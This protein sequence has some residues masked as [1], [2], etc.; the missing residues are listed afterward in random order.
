[1]CQKT[2]ACNHLGEFHA[3]RPHPRTRAST[4]Q[5]SSPAIA[6][7]ARARQRAPPAQP[8]SCVTQIV[9]R[10]M[11][12]DRFQNALPPI[13]SNGGGA[14][15]VERGEAGRWKRSDSMEIP[16]Q[17]CPA[18]TDTNRGSCREAWRD[19]G[20]SPH[21]LSICGDVSPKKKQGERQHR[22][23]KSWEIGPRP[24]GSIVGIKRKAVQQHKTRLGGM[25]LRVV[26]KFP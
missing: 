17:D 25:V 15:T 2:H 12:G 8:P 14:E 11:L 20:E 5:P 24:A 7:L 22:K 18:L 9:N 4:P 23:R 13:P 3:P 26:L 16:E 10:N 21:H 19:H 1:M 6:P